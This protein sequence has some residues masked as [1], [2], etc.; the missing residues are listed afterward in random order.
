MKKRKIRF[1][2]VLVA[3]LLCTAAAFWVAVPLGICALAAA[4]VA[5]YLAYKP[6]IPTP[7]PLWYQYNF[8]LKPLFCKKA[9]S[10]KPGLGGYEAPVFEALAA[11]LYISPTGNDANDGTKDAPFATF[12]RARQAV[13]ALDR[14]GRNAVTVAVMAGEYAVEKITFDGFDS[15]SEDCPV[16]YKA[17]G[18]EAVLNGG[19]DLPIDAFCKVTEESILHRLTPQARERV[20][21]A[22][23]KKLGLTK[24]QIGVIHAFGAFHLADRYD[25]DWVGPLHCELFVDDHR[26]TLA[27]YPNGDAYLKTDRPISFVGGSETEQTGVF[28][29]EFSKLRN[30]TGDLYRVNK[31]LA[32]R[33]SSWQSL[34]DVWMFGYWMYDWAD[35]STPIESFD[36]EKQTLAPKFISQWGAKKGAPY[37]FFN[38]LEELDAP[39]EWYLDRTS[40]KLYLYPDGKLD[41]KN[42]SLSITQESIL[43]IRGATFLTFDGFT[44]KGTRGDAVTIDADHISL[45]NC[46]VKNVAGNAMVINGTGNTVSNCHITR[47]GKAGILIDGGDRQTLTPGGNVVENC[48]I[49]SWSEI[50]RTYCPAVQLSGVGNICRHNEMYDSPH[51][52]IWY[53]GN[54]HIIEYNHIHHACLLTKD[55]GAIYAGKNWSYYGSHVRY[56]C[57][58]DLGSREF[59]ACG[60][61]M[62]DGVS[63]QNIYGNLL[64]NIPGI[65]IQLGGGRD[66][67]VTDNVIVNCANAP[68]YYDNRA[69]EGALH[70]AWFHYCSEPEGFMWK[71][72]WD[73]P[74]KTDVWQKHYP[75]MAAFCEDFGRPEDPCFVPNP[76]CSRV[77]DNL[78]LDSAPICR[79]IICKEAR[80]FGRC[81]NNKTHSMNKLGEIFAEPQNGNYTRK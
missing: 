61:Y 58:H 4:I 28:A 53:H 43:D 54:D 34:E 78:I 69:R 36:S 17:L 75:Q 29:P 50:Y 37:Y 25:G 21:V 40:L 11:D 45:R 44:L 20:L 30:P 19:F 55:G 68:L 38:V 27:R 47:T 32:K 24:E 23:L 74:Y 67:T 13:R 81:Q 70:G 76:G 2:F 77:E 46:T 79:N 60:I 51:E 56:N 62:D 48:L 15:G 64:V 35:S 42:I 41:G 26:Q 65:A 49:H 59:V 52:V 31:A 72:L 18:G 14:T 80:R 39:G 10:P 73:S 12:E 9:P 16:I 33:I 57:I 3:S 22:D 5:I 71:L 8:R 66:F 6:L 63:G 7:E 1:V